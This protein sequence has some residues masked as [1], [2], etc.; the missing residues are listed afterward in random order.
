MNKTFTLI[1][2]KTF[3]VERLSLGGLG[4]TLFGFIIAYILLFDQHGVSPFDFFLEIRFILTASIFFALICFITKNITL[5]Y[6]SLGLRLVTLLL[7]TAMFGMRAPIIEFLVVLPFLLEVILQNGLPLGAY[8]SVLFILAGGAVKISTVVPADSGWFFTQ[9][10]LVS[11]IYC[12]F[13]VLGSLVIF[14]REKIVD[15]TEQVEHLNQSVA[16]LCDANRAFLRYADEVESESTEQERNRITRELHDSFSYAL[17]NI[18]TS[19]KAGKLLSKNISRDL[20]GLLDL[21]QRQAEQALQ[22]TRQTLHK[23]RAVVNRQP[24]GLQALFHLIDSFGS[25][26]GAEAALHRG[27]VPDTLGTQLDTAIF[28]FVQEALT[29]AFRHGKADKIDVFLWQTDDAIRIT[30]QDNGIGADSITEGIGINGMRERFSTFGGT[31]DCRNITSGFEI[32]VTIP[33]KRYE[34]HA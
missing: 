21:T 27:N 23:L 16:N 17:V 31:V 6:V 10:I 2:L 30:V 33:F 11:G 25:A 8:L 12:F 5:Y 18:I 24:E 13:A 32:R 7:F 9:V 4:L 28:R 1:P 22:D 3:K 14:Y 26:T 15:L 34:I 19:M 29:N 20:S